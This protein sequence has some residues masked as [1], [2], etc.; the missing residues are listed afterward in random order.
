M[1]DLAAFSKLLYPS[2]QSNGSGENNTLHRSD[3]LYDA[4]DAGEQADIIQRTQQAKSDERRRMS[5][6]N[7]GPGSSSSSAKAGTLSSRRASSQSTVA[8]GVQ[9]SFTD[10]KTQRDDGEDEGRSPTTTV[11]SNSSRQDETTSSGI[12]KRSRIH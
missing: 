10:R 3:P 2:Y 12:L 8:K 1:Q 6:T 7:A 11:S 9:M 4:A 5:R